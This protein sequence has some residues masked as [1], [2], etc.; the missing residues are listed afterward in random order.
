MGYPVNF[1]G[2]QKENNMVED[3][4]QLPPTPQNNPTPNKVGKKEVDLFPAVIE[5]NASVVSGVR[6]GD[7]VRGT[8]FSMFS[9]TTFEEALDIV[10]CLRS[11]AATTICLDKMR[12]VD[13]VRLVD[14]ITGASSALDGDF[15]KMS[16][17][18]YLFCPSNIRIMTRE[19]KV[20]GTK[21]TTSA[22]D[23][24][25]PEFPE[26]SDSPKRVFEDFR[27]TH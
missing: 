26:K 11:R 10:A 8:Q 1:F 9:P 12:K 24:L 18:V 20:A 23:Y 19:D 25:Y 14:F 4:Q 16:E 5:R 3:N 22:L 15:Q 2:W 21:S 7:V 6:S 27:P 13:A 17:S